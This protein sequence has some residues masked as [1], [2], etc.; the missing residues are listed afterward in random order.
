MLTMLLAGTIALAAPD[1]SGI[2]APPAPRLPTAAELHRYRI[3]AARGAAV[4][5][6]VGALSLAVVGTAVGAY[7]TRNYR[8]V[9]VI[10]G[11]AI[12]FPTGFVLG[13]I[14][15]AVVGHRVAGGL[16]GPMV[17]LATA[18]A[19]AGSAVVGLTVGLID[20]G[21]GVGVGALLALSTPVAAAWA[22]GHRVPPDVVLVPTVV[23]GAPGL[24]V[25]GRF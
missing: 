16:N 8:E 2:Q 3:R 19:M 1:L 18:G 11:P 4:G 6:V 5:E 25:S 15:G 14:A 13:G 7:A 24:G 20:G 17:G 12:G 22:A 23:G 10:I 9:G 21:A